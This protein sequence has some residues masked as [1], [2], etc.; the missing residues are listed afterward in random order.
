MENTDYY[1]DRDEQ[2]VYYE[3]LH[4]LD[5]YREHYEAE[6]TV[7]EVDDEQETT[8][9]DSLEEL[10]EAVYNVYNTPTGDHRYIYACKDRDGD[11]FLADERKSDSWNSY[12]KTVGLGSTYDSLYSILS[13]DMSVTM[14]AAA[15]WGETAVK[16]Y[17]EK[18][19]KQI[20]IALSFAL[21]D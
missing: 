4:E 7:E 19:K 3:R 8:Y 18:L 11:Y 2:D 15:Y 16:S 10:A 9:Y 6:P 21:Y 12:E 17:V 13:E 1:N 5:N 14:D 20:V